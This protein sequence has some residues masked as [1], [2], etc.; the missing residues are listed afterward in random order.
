M[1]VGIQLDD[2]GIDYMDRRNGLIE[3]VTLEDAKRVAARLYQPDNLT[4]VVVGKPDGLEP[5]REAPGGS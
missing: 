1:L 5:T 3:A 4:I 2:L